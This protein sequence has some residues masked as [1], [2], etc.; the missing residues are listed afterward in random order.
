MIWCDTDRGDVVTHFEN[1]GPQCPHCG[2]KIIS[3]GKFC[4]ACGTSLSLPCPDC[5]FVNPPDFGFCGRCGAR[6]AE[7]PVPVAEP[8]PT[9]TVEAPSPERA[10]LEA[11]VAR[12]RSF[13]LT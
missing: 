6:L 12:P 4:G 5:G 8:P 9:Q 13:S 10:Q 11:N 2:A 1:E 7:E 3:A